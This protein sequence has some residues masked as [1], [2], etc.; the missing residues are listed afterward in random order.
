MGFKK[1]EAVNIMKIAPAQI[2]VIHVLKY[3]KAILRLLVALVQITP[4]LQI[5]HMPAKYKDVNGL[6][7]YQTVAVKPRHILDI[8]ME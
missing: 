3:H 1:L 5:P 2:V 7:K 8:L 4:P 6:L